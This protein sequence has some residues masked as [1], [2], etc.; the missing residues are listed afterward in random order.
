MTL[1]YNILVTEN[2]HPFPMPGDLVKKIA[3][4]DY[5][6]P[7]KY[8]NVL[9]LVSDLDVAKIYPVTYPGPEKL[10]MIAK[11]IN[12]FCATLGLCQQAPDDVAVFLWPVPFT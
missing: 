9:D 1:N 4:G 10:I 5:P 2:A 6:F 8:I 7:A 12:H 11:D 3:M